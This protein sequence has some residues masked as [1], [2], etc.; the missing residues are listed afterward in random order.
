MAESY[1]VEAVLTAKD[2]NFS[3]TFAN[4]EKTAGTFGSKLKSGLAAGAAVGIGAVTALGVATVAA[5]K[6]MWQG[7]NTTAQYGDNVDKM[8]QKI[9]ISAE[10][11]Q[12][13]NYVMKRAGT[14]IDNMKMGM[15][16]LSKQA[17][18]GSDAFQKLGISQEKVKSLSQEDLFS[19]VVKGLSNMEAGTERAALASELLGRAGAD[20]GPLLNEGSAAIEEQ[21]DIA[22]KY[23]MVMSD[24]AVKASAAFEDSLTTLQMTATGLKNRLMSE[25]LP[26]VTQVTDGLAKLFTGDMSGLDDIS[27]G[28]S[29]LV[30]KIAE[31]LPKVIE[32]GGSIVLSL[33]QAIVT[34][35]PALINAGTS[36]VL[37]LLTGIIQMLPQLLTA[38]VQ[39]IATII[40]GLAQ[41][42][43]T[44]IPTMVQ[45]VVT[46]V[47]GLIN[48]IDLLISASVQLIGGIVTGLINA[49]PQLMAAMPKLIDTMVRGL[50][51]N[52]N[53]LIA[54]AGKLIQ[55]IVKGIIQNL[56]Q[57]LQQGIQIVSKLIS[58]ILQV[59]G[60]LPATARN[61]VSQFR[62]VW[63]GINWGSIGSAI[64]R[65]I[66]NGIKSGASA[67]ASAAKSA[68]KN[69]LNAAK[70][71]LGIH[72]PSRVFRDEVGKNVAL[73]FAEGIADNMGYVYSAMDSLSATAQASFAGNLSESYD[74]NS[75]STIIVPLE[76]DGKEF[77]RATAPYNIAENNKAQARA[78]RAKGWR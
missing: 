61:L 30:S 15:K 66:A 33:V 35:L 45:A 18:S 22:E 74:Y 78:N 63:S 31:V 49:L 41:A 75:R 58:G 51:A 20:L 27:A 5:G 65:G 3:S 53:L 40:Q 17:E 25:F 7:I 60:Q 48:N 32:V 77:A 24:E 46:M 68:A 57:I 37:T 50:I 56:P 34:N 71:L 47:E 67:I 69:A 39:S 70:S 76:I 1:S 6:K 4:A 14:S 9:G 42:M 11:Y 44:L 36:L 13:W 2:Q 16:T 73:G 12:K 8:S 55:A 21:M 64:V 26:A 29:N 52:I 72:S 10:A 43:P 38:G 59:A 19:E 54:C 28:I 23:G 62:N